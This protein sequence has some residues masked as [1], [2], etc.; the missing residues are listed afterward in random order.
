ML[1][2]RVVEVATMQ[3]RPGRAFIRRSFS[4]RQALRVSAELCS[5]TQR[6]WILGD[7]RE[8][9]SPLLPPPPQKTNK[10][11]NFLSVSRSF[12]SPPRLYFFHLLYCIPRYLYYPAEDVHSAETVQYLDDHDHGE[13]R[14]QDGGDFDGAGNG[15]HVSKSCIGLTIVHLT[16]AQLSRISLARA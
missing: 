8:C 16:E 2:C 5:L 4:L 14:V 10:K 13:G 9:C 1:L 11:A 3:R 7:A 15:D 6:C 12:F